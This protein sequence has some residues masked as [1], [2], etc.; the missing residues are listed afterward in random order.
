MA[1]VKVLSLAARKKLKRGLREEDETWPSRDGAFFRT[2]RTFE[3]LRTFAKE[4]LTN[5]VDR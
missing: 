3:A 4:A 5:R 1:C 2:R